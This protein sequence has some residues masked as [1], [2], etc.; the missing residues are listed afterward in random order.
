MGVRSRDGPGCRAHPAQGWGM[1]TRLLPRHLHCVSLP[2]QGVGDAEGPW[3]TKDTR[4]GDQADEASP[5]LFRET[6]RLQSSEQLP[7]LLPGPG[8]MGCFTLA[9]EHL[10]YGHRT[11]PVTSFSRP[12]VWV[13]APQ[14]RNLATG[15]RRKPLAFSC[16][17]LAVDPCW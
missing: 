4:G 12:G 13:P 5:G 17:F 10:P 14:S 9:L 6:A 11:P 3:G 8:A 2:N 1:L 15:P 16:H 7:F